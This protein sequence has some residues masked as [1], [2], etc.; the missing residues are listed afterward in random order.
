MSNCALQLSRP[1][2]VT[3]GN[4]DRG[5]SSL[6][7]RNSTPFLVANSG[8]VQVGTHGT[9][10]TTYTRTCTRTH[11]LHIH[12]NFGVWDFETADSGFVLH[13][14][15]NTSST[16][17]CAAALTQLHCWT[18]SFSANNNPGMSA[19]GTSRPIEVVTARCGSVA[20]VAFVFS[21][22]FTGLAYL[23]VRGGLQEE[24]RES[25]E[26]EK[27]RRKEKKR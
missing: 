13:H 20:K 17:L 10:T 11:T 8:M 23:T 19:D 22:C 15:Q 14:T 1:I 5:V 4:C 26:K 16:I 2:I 24:E 12:R 7:L 21:S 18:N 27:K 3:L 25:E 9:Y 6:M